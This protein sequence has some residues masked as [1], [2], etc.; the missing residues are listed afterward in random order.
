MGVGQFG[1]AYR[2]SEALRGEFS[3]FQTQF[4]PSTARRLRCR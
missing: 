4:Y 3:D 2:R 1:T